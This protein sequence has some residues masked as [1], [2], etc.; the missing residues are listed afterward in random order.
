MQP[1]TLYRAGK[2]SADKT[3]PLIVVL[4]NNDAKGFLFKNVK[5]LKN[6]EKW[7]NI[8]IRDDKTKL[9]IHYDKIRDTSMI[10]KAKLQNNAMNRSEYNQGYRWVAKGRSGNKHLSKVKFDPETIFG[11][12]TMNGT[13]AGFTVSP[14]NNELTNPSIQEATDS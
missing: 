7:A 11:E 10:E 13:F 8:S 14:G 2:P 9:Q 5:N 3:R 1:K 12:T 6:N 4:D